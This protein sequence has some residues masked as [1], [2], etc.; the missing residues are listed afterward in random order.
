MESWSPQTKLK[1]GLCTLDDTGRIASIWNFPDFNELLREIDEG[2]ESTVQSSARSSEVNGDAADSDVVSDS[3]EGELDAIVT[4]RVTNVSIRHS[5]P[6]TEDAAKTIESD[7]NA[8][9]VA[10]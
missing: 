6:L 3:V 7:G 4:F 1:Y 9:L 10:S 8:K 5:L 2:E